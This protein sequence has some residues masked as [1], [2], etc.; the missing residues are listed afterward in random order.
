MVGA[1]APTSVVSLSVS[2]ILSSQ[3]PLSS[4]RAIIPLGPLLLKASS[5]PPENKREP[6]HMSSYLILLRT[7][8]SCFHS[9]GSS[10]VSR[11]RHQSHSL[12]HSFC[13]TGPRLTT[14]GRYPLCCSMKSGLSSTG[15]TGL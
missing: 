5:D 13:S 14:E 4:G 7:E 3:K 9:N 6:R 15:I 12:G 1:E 10:R 8:F 11:S 2:R